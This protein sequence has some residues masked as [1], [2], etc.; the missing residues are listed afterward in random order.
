M[1]LEE[2]PNHHKHPARFWRKVDK[3]GPDDCWEWQGW[4]QAGPDG[5]RYGLISVG[6]PPHRRSKF[7]HRIAYMLAHGEVPND[8]QVCHTCDNMACCN[9]SHLFVGTHTD[10][11]R[12]MRAKRRGFMPPWKGEECPSA[13][14]TAAQVREI[15]HKA[16]HTTYVALAKEYGTWPQT[17]GRIVRREAWKVVE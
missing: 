10:N 9:P 16:T 2:L 11:M 7:T 12:D 13:K 6:T 15:R 8:L 1:R 5:P 14:L 3:L 4:R 17:I